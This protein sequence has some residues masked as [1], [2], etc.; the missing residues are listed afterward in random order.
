MSR[1]AFAVLVAASAVF[2]G[3]CG[4]DDETTDPLGSFEL[5][6]APT[7][8]SVQ[9]GAS[10]TLNVSITRSGFDDAVTVTV[11]NVPIG[12]TAASATIAAGAT[13]TSVTV[14]AAATATIGV[15]TFTVR[16]TGAGVGQRSASVQLTV[17]AAPTPSIALA[18]APTSLSIAQGQT[19]SAN[20]TITRSNFTGAVSL[21]AGGGPGGMT[22]A[23]TPTSVTGTTSSM[24][25]AVATTVAPGSY[26]ITVQ[27]TGTG[28]AITTAILTVT[29]T[30]PPASITL[31]AAPQ[32][33]TITQGQSGT[34]QLTITRTNFIGAVNLTSSAPAGITVTLSPTSATGTSASA[35]IAV[36]ASLVAG[37]Y[38]V[39]I[40]GAGA[41]I[42][43][44][45]VVLSITVTVPGGTGNVTFTFCAQSGIPLWFA[46]SDNGGAFARVTSAT[47]A[48]NFTVGQ[49]GRVAWVMQDGSKTR[50]E[51]F[52]GSL[53]DLNAR[54]RSFCRG[55][56]SSKTINVAA[57]G[58]AAGQRAV[59][60]MGAGSGQVL[61]PGNTTQLSNVQD[62]LLDLIG[63]RQ[64]TAA[65]PVTNSIV[66]VRDRNDAPGSTV[67][68]DLNAGVVPLTRTATIANLGAD[69]G[70]LT[71]SFLSK[72]GT[73]ANLSGDVGG[74]TTSRSWSAVP[75]ASVVSGDWH[76]QTVIATP[77]S[78]TTGFPF[79]TYSVF[80]Q[81]GT[82][83]TLPLPDYIMAEPNFVVSSTVPYVTF[84]SQWLVQSAQ[85]ND[86][87]S[88]VFTPASGNVS[89]VT[90]SGTVGYFGGGPARLDLPAFDATFNPQHGLQAGIPL[91]W[92]FF[93]AGGTAWGNSIGH[94]PLPNEGEFSTTAGIR[95]TPFTP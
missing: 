82:D 83:R 20:L 25:V 40:Q 6:V 16:A 68:I 59:I 86:F 84:A 38:A 4:D 71:A 56:G 41:G 93:A 55:N 42:S 89:S 30:G 43:N 95:G 49:R 39:T 18:V 80:T 90:I 3:S 9:V 13:S 11:E 47:G 34:S 19:A 92:T 77:A 35:T 91:T 27:G 76:L 85:Y 5:A 33:L 63:V 67:S 7:S 88:L 50:L 46:F 21:S 51:L 65:N 61:G 29:V 74:I 10:A 75:D 52:Y 24:S 8:L 26:P 44:A 79:R 1:R 37:T 23:F 15:S 73:T 58:V 94:A 45:T 64:T 48:F 32:A 31:S 2:L 70:F 57:A 72:N 81:L 12:V 17:V 69:Q 22:F 36:S 62:G 53:Q 14:N 87:W 60:S 28:V 78:S 66:I 54:G